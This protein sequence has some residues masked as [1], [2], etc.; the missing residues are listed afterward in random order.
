MRAIGLLMLLCVLGF[1]VEILPQLST[2]AHT[3]IIKKMVVSYDG[4]EIITSSS[5]KSVR[6]WDSATMSEKR[7]ILGE[8]S[9][10]WGGVYSIAVSPDSNILATGGMFY[11]ERDT[12]RA[13]T[14]RLFDY[15]TGKLLK[16]LK[17]HTDVI[18]DLDFSPDGKTIVS[19]SADSSVRFWDAKTGV[20]IKAHQYNAK[21]FLQ[22]EM[23]GSGGYLGVR[24]MSN[25]YVVAIGKHQLVHI[26]DINKGQISEKYQ[27]AAVDSVA[28]GGGYIAIG[29]IDNW[30]T[31]YDKQFGFVAEFESPLPINALALSK[32]GKQL[33]VS[34]ASSTKDSVV[35][36]YKIPEFTEQ[37]KLPFDN[38]VRAAAFLP[39]GKALA[40]GGSSFAIKSFSPVGK[41]D[42]ASTKE[43]GGG[44]FSVGIK[45]DKI[46]FGNTFGSEYTRNN[47]SPFEKIFD[48]KEFALS[49]ASKEKIGG[50][51]RV[52]TSW[53][54][55]SLEV[56][57]NERELLIRQ[58]GKIVSSIVRSQNNGSLHTVFGFTPNG[59][60]V[61]GGRFGHLHL[62]NIKGDLLVSFVGHS[63]DILSLA[64]NDK[65][66]VSGSGDQSFRVWSLDG[67]AKLQPKDNTKWLQS[68]L[69]AR[70]NSEEHKEWPIN[71]V[72]EMKSAHLA[73]GNFAAVYEHKQMLPL[74]SIFVS[75][76]DD[77]V[78]WTPEGYFT[79]SKEGAKYLGYH[80]NRGE[81]KEAT[82]VSMDRMYDIFY[83]T[84]IV[85][86]KLSGEDVSKYTALN[87]ED[88]LAK[89]P[90]EAKITKVTPSSHGKVKV[91]YQ[92]ASTGGGI[93]EVRL[94]HNGKLVYSDGHY[95]DSEGVLKKEEA[96][97][98]AQNSSSI[99][100]GNERALKKIKESSTAKSTIISEGKGEFYE[101]F[102][103]TWAVSG[104]NEYAL[105][106]F[107][108]NNTAQSAF[109]T[110]E[111]IS[112]EKPKAPKLYVVSVGVDKFLESDANLK[113][114]AKD[115]NDF[116]VLFNKKAESLFS[117]QNIVTKV[118]SN[119]EATKQN[120]SAALNE[121]A[122]S[123]QPQDVF[124]FFGASHGVL[125][126]GQYYLVTHTYNG[127]LDPN[128][129]I[130]SND[131]INASKQIPS[132][133]QLFILDTC[134]A[135]GLD[136]VMS[137]LYDSKMSVLAKKSGLH[138]YA[139]AGSQQTAIDGYKGN[140]LF[141]HVLLNALNEPIKVDSNK[142]GSVSVEEMGVFA[143]DVTS[144]ISAGIGHPQTP[145]II[146]FGKDYDLI[147][148]K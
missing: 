36:V 43:I 13:G 46:A 146:H 106:A 133:K 124:V 66:L 80:V 3:S 113:Y 60:I 6:V 25:N 17:G 134:H 18:N 51:E 50:F 54:G 12:K 130:S 1:S 9:Q 58:N 39:N 7:Q 78:V 115:A 28:A 15:K 137:G 4:K 140:G 126:D 14:I 112:N 10:E 56:G 121:M 88:A 93:G 22:K 29:C 33:L 102:F 142:Q 111:F 108:A 16:L 87:I 144:S 19:V 8:M 92:V 75:K 90:P 42:I 68:E 135:G 24:F 5:D 110:K 105:S 21:N 41:M 72:G 2:G 86:M 26:Y 62:F 147:K 89:T 101:S 132:F 98:S 94:F 139:S 143:K 65:W 55:Y 117:K 52:S 104:Q 74:A 138:I 34:M 44:I 73:S 38:L 95:S 128:T 20:L 49:K 119:E 85:R 40:A 125:F 30:I 107:N 118:I 109:G 136:A 82:F 37:N 76:G 59:L 11:D 63:V 69:E 45:G 120:I 127:V 116:R 71:S 64:A 67:L 77:W 122:N 31:I 84:D 70:K 32:D 61:S 91:F 97:L 47:N 123:A 129:M 27:A 48:M 79:A 53:N 114:A 57:K 103:E 96:K 131:I 81:S 83:R 145:T 141:T 23:D 100:G 148:T 35:K 99:K